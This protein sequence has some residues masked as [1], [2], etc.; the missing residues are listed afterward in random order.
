MLRQHIPKYLPQVSP[1]PF[2]SLNSLRTCLLANCSLA[3]ALSSYLLLL[4]LGLLLSINLKL[5]LSTSRISGAAYD[6]GGVHKPGQ[7]LQVTPWKSSSASASAPTDVPLA[8]ASRF[9]IRT[10]GKR[11][12]PTCVYIIYIYIIYAYNTVGGRVDVSWAM[13]ENQ[14]STESGGLLS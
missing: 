11:Y 1:T 13:G 14:Q 5:S 10:C 2:V 9:C 4:A 6:D 7:L 3:R 12:N 8:Y